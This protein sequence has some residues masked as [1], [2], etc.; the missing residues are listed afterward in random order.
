MEGS[1]LNGLFQRIQLSEKAFHDRA[2]Q[3]RALNE[4]LQKKR[5]QHQVQRSETRRA[6]AD[7]DAIRR[8]IDAQNVE[9]KSRRSRVEIL[10]AALEKTTKEKTRIDAEVV[11]VKKRRKIAQSDFLVETTRFETTHGLSGSGRDER[12]AERKRKIEKSASKLKKVE[13]E[14]EERKTRENRLANA[15]DIAAT[16]DAE[17]ADLKWKSINIDGNL[18]Q[19]RKLNSALERETIALERGDRD[20]ESMRRLRFEWGRCGDDEKRIETTCDTLRK[21]LK[22]LEEARRRNDEKEGEK[23]YFQSDSRRIRYRRRKSDVVS[24]PPGFSSASMTGV[25]CS[26]S[27]QRP[28]DDVQDEGPAQVRR[29]KRGQS[30][31][32]TCKRVRFQENC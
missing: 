9:L 12:N 13:D 14:L 26:Q 16:T 28:S 3:I 22:S 15:T 23:E 8:R 32:Q 29:R 6:N 31:S 1:S 21:E 18:R 7:I 17:I 25:I 4:Q 11:D 2:V 5:I 20:D 10:A 27:S 19:Q 24:P 30:T